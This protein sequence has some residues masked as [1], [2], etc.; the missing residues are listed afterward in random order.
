MIGSDWVGL[1]TNKRKEFSSEESVVRRN[2][3]KLK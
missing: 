2:E 1:D 3:N